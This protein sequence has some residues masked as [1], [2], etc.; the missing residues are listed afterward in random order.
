V[1]R[2]SL[3]LIVSLV[4][5]SLVGLFGAP[6][7][8]VAGST[9]SDQ[10]L[11]SELAVI[12]AT[13]A[14]QCYLTALSNAGF[15]PAAGGSALEAQGVT[16]WTGQR[17]EGQALMAFVEKHNGAPTAS[18]LT[19]ARQSIED[20]FT[21]AAAAKSYQCSG[22]PAQALAAMTPAMLAF[23]LRAQ[24]DAAW[25]ETA[26]PSQ[27]PLTTTGLEAYFT[28]H[29]QN[30]QTLCVAV[31]VVPPKLKDV[32]EA[33]RQAGKSIAQLATA[34]SLDKSAAN[35]GAYGCWKPSS[36]YYAIWRKLTGSLPLNSFMTTP[37][38]IVYGTGKAF[39]YVAVTAR[40]PSTFAD[41]A[42]AVL[43]DAK[44]YNASGAGRA[45][46]N[47]LFKTPVSVSAAFGRWALTSQG[48]QVAS[49]AA[50]LPADVLSPGVLTGAIR[51]LTS[52]R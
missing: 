1:R 21:Q 49:L 8:R 28:A 36:Q 22:T 11:R 19:A 5:A 31:A 44:A 17:V 38:S 24:A 43:A 26:M 46:A 42:P 15:N 48:P 14:L 30:Y 12:H 39:L 34:Y 29:A 33:D 51:S 20:E 13:P 25:L 37:R 32:F 9:V 45:K 6:A 35:G 41:A 4:G 40:T 27:I 3:L 18:A 2:L 50:P 52:Y 23:E 10:E 16:A 47:I 7:L